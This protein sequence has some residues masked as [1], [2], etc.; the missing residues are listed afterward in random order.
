MCSENCDRCSVEVKKKM[1]CS[2]EILMNCSAEI[3]SVKCTNKCIRDLE[4]GH[5]CTRPCFE[6]CQP[7]REKVDKVLPSCGHTVQTKCGTDIAL[8]VCMKKCKRKLKCD[9]PCKE[10]CAESCTQKC[11][12]KAGFIVSHCGHDVPL[13]CWE[14]T[15][16]KK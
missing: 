10:Q 13:F 12:E 11:N 16:G 6:T 8:I 5:L 15:E 2:H 1:E 9:H 3:N 14:N 7:C 4:C